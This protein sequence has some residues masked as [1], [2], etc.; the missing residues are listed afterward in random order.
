MLCANIHYGVPTCLCDCGMQFSLG[1]SRLNGFSPSSFHGKNHRRYSISA[2]SPCMYKQKL[3]TF[4]LSVR[5]SGGVQSTH[6][7]WHLVNAYRQMISHTI[8]K[9][10][11]VASIGRARERLGVRA[12]TKMLSRA[13]R[14]AP[15]KKW[16]N[17]SCA[18]R[19]A[20][21]PDSRSRRNARTGTADTLTE[22]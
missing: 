9:N 13:S 8:K 1:S 19:A 7:R 3:I 16:K 20:S 10:W 15:F 21:A 6:E 17:R 14:E 5:A 22:R 12:T 18:R 2:G 4:F 11:R